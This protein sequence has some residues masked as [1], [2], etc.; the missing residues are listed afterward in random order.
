M[1]F[2]GQKCIEVSDWSAASIFR[3][4]YLKSSKKHSENY[5]LLAASLLAF[6]PCNSVL[7]I[8]VV[9][10]SETSANAYQTA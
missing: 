8:E 9:S 3:K 4:L 6:S 5:T 7:K 10:Y 2:T 1:P